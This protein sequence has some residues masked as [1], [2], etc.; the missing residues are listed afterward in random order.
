ML[1]RSYENPCGVYLPMLNDE[2][3]IVYGDTREMSARCTGKESSLLPAAVLSDLGSLFRGNNP[4]WL[5][6][7]VSNHRVLL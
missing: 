3:C 7:A 4:R 5:P 6:T 1:A 2:W